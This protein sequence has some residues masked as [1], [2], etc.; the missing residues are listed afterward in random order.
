MSEH[1]SALDT[2]T[3]AL[4]SADSPLATNLAEILTDTI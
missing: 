3:G 1:D 2:H 4:T